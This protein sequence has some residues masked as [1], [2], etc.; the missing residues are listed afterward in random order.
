MIQPQQ[1][2]KKSLWQRIKYK[3]AW[4]KFV[5]GTLKYVDSDMKKQQADTFLKYMKKINKVHD[6]HWETHF[7]HLM[8]LTLFASCQN[9]RR[10]RTE[11]KQ[12]KDDIATFFKEMDKIII[13][14]A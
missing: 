9:L 8:M 1:P 13:D 10:L 14:V 4:K 11:Y 2:K 3:F 12:I 5:K 6:L 7:P